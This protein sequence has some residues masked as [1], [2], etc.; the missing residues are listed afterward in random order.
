VNQFGHGFGI[1]TEALLGDGGN[2]AGAGF[3][4]R[5]VEFLVTLILLEVGG[6]GGRQKR[7]LVMI[8][9]PGNFGGTGIFKVNDGVLVAVKILFIKEGASTVQQAGV[10]ELD[11][12][13]NP[14]AVET[15]EKRRRRGA[16]KAFIVIEHSNSQSCLPFRPESDRLPEIEPESKVNRNS[17]LARVG[18]GLGYVGSRS[19]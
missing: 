6:I 17:V 7:A 2:E 14:L 9:P 16:V 15:G 4:V 13:A 12:V 19:V 1:E 5:V 18:Q 8:E 10:H 3:E 11:V